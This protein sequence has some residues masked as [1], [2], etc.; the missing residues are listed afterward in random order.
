MSVFAHCKVIL[1]MHYC[2][3]WIPVPNDTNHPR[4]SYRD[5]C[6]DGYGRYLTVLFEWLHNPNGIYAQVSLS[7]WFV[8]WVPKLDSGTHLPKP[9]SP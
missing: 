6:S 9:L 5:H 7:V 4:W 8:S 3:D 1:I 2:E